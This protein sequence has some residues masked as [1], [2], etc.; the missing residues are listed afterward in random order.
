MKRFRIQAI[1]IP[2]L[3]MVLFGGCGGKSSGAYYKD[4][5]KYFDEGNYKEAGI[6]FAQAIEKN[7]ERAE[8]YIDYGMALI[9]LGKSKEALVNFDRAILDKD[10]AIVNRNNKLAYRG[11]GIAY[12]KSHQYTNAVEQFDKA[13]KVD[14]LSDLNMDILYYKGSAQESAGLYKEAAA[15]YTNILSGNPKDSAIYNSRAFAYR[16]MGDYEKS[17]ADYDKAISI[18]KTNYDYYFGKYF[19]LLESKDAKGAAEALDAAAAIPVKTQEDKFN[20]A[21]IHYYKEDYDT[22]VKEFG[23][24]FKN[25]FTAAYYYLGGIYEKKGDYKS[26]ADNYQLF[27][28][29]Q[30]T[31]KTASV[32]NQ[33]GMC[34]IKQGQYEKALSYIKTGLEY[35]D[36]F[37]NRSLKQNEIVAYEN[38]GK[39][40]DAYRLMSEYI[41]LYPE[42]EKA[43]D[44]YEYIK[45]RLP[46][47]STGQPADKKTDEK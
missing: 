4:G 30:T 47:V 15:T 1:V 8:Y 28:D 45:T 40:E 33:I 9:M 13:L 26:A 10:N 11:K 12:L 5:L 23:E 38:L 27:I 25:G 37:L 29:D 32:Y 31:E 6:S 17:L 41:S 3:A 34:L 39:Y 20:L 19:L 21:K 36:N 42:D 16:K 35:K 46:E 44:E 18:D 22:A 43:A 24:A 7:S 14:E 2:L